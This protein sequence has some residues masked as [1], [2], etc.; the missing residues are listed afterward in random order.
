MTKQEKLDLC[1]KLLDRAKFLLEESY[2]VQGTPC[3]T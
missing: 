1:F 2:K 3:F